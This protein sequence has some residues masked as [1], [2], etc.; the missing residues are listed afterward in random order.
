MVSGVDPGAESFEV[1]GF[2]VGLGEADEVEV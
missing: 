2:D 1:L